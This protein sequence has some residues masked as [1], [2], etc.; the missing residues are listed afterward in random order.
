ML[1]LLSLLVMVLPTLPH[2]LWAVGVE[3]PVSGQGPDGLIS[4]GEAP[5]TGCSPRL[6]IDDAVAPPS[7]PGSRSLGTALAPTLR[8]RSALS[9]GINADAPLQRPPRIVA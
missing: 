9:L 4:Q 5:S 8:G 7:L 3:A 1:V 6:E 2:G